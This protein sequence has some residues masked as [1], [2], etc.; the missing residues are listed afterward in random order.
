MGN[1]GRRILRGSLTGQLGWYTQ[2]STRDSASNQVDDEDRQPNYVQAATVG[3][4]SQNAQ[5]E[6]HILFH[7]FQYHLSS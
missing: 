2:H 7:K 5:N 6:I 3:R 1:W 4:R